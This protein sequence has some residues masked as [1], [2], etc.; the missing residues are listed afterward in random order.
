MRGD[1]GDRRG[2]GGGVDGERR[3]KMAAV[4]VVFVVVKNAGGSDGCGERRLKMA[5]V[6]VVIV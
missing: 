6:R 1:C 4:M 5:V 3:L 2:S